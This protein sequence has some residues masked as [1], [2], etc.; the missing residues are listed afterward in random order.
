MEKVITEKRGLVIIL[1]IATVFVFVGLVWA[2]A[3]YLPL[4]LSGLPSPSFT[5]TTPLAG[6]NCTYPVAYWKNHPELYPAQLIIGGQVYKAKDI[7]GIF[8]DETADPTVQ[9]QAQLAG[10][11]LNFLSGADQSYVEATIFEAY[12]WLVKHPAG[13]VLTDSEREAGTRLFTILQTYNQGLTEVALCEPGIFL[14]IT[15]TITATGTPTILLTITPSQTISTTPS[16]T[17][18]QTSSPTMVLTIVRTPT[19]TTGVPGAP[20]LTPTHRISP[21]ATDTPVNTIA[22]PTL[23]ATST[24]TNTPTQTFTPTDTPTFTPLPSPTFTFTPPPSPTFTFTPPPSPTYTFTPPPS[25][26]P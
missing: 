10:A 17:P 11:Y 18:A 1:V 7:E 21:S 12:G 9:L 5:A 20:S 15:G 14:T 23:A 16:E 6:K 25:P 24:P 2:I 3:T 13:S 26:T 8:L 22:P 4:N 19:P